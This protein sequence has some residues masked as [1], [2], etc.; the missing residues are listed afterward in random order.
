MPRPRGPTYRS[1]PSNPIY[2]DYDEMQE[3][4]E[5]AERMSYP[6][7]YSRKNNP[8][9]GV[10]DIEDV[11]DDYKPWDWGKIS[12]GANYAGQAAQYISNNY[13]PDDE[14][15]WLRDPKTGNYIYVK[16]KGDPSDPN[17]FSNPY[18]RKTNRRIRN[19]M[20][21][22]AIY[23]QLPKLP[24]Q[25]STTWSPQQDYLSIRDPV[26]RDPNFIMGTGSDVQYTGR[27]RDE[28]IEYDRSKDIKRAVD[29]YKAMQRRVADEIASKE[30]TIDYKTGYARSQP[31]T[32]QEGDV[33]TFNHSEYCFD[34]VSATSTQITTTMSSFINTGGS[35]GYYKVKC[36]AGIWSN[37]PILSAFASNFQ[38]YRW[39][40]LIFKYLTTSAD[41]VS[42][43]NTALGQGVMTCLYNVG[44]GDF[45]SRQQME[46]NG[47][48]TVFKPSQDATF[49]VN[50]EN[51]HVPWFYTRY[52]PNTYSGYLTTQQ[53]TQSV[54]MVDFVNFY[55]GLF[56]SQNSNTVG[57]LWAEYEVELSQPY[58][59]G[60][61]LGNSILY[62]RYAPVTGNQA[63][64]TLIN[65]VLA[66]PADA[67][68]NKVDAHG[69]LS[70]TIGNTITGPAG[71][72]CCKVSFPSTLSAGVFRIMY[73][74]GI[75]CTTSANYFTCFNNDNTING[76][77][78]FL[79][80]LYL[81][82][83]QPGGG[84]PNSTDVIIRQMATS[85]ECYTAFA[86]SAPST[87]ATVGQLTFPGN[88]YA[89][90]IAYIQIL[91]PNA[92]FVV[93]PQI[94]TGSAKVNPSWSNYTPGQLT[95]EQCNPDFMYGYFANNY[96]SPAY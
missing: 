59:F 1:D 80:P 18:N 50:C 63:T 55:I 68:G 83:H 21:N 3:A 44:S 46:N 94:G 11:P 14:E 88:T 77:V 64:G 84:T 17:Y 89:Y 52:D 23:T 66:Q 5:R 27:T 34:I 41:S 26:F 81:P 69:N 20:I 90:E 56:S 96:P 12:E 43:T 60:N 93:S 13:D 8:W 42:A 91:G 40:K 32:T 53:G 57:Q 15:E 19:T 85:A 51:Q 95:I 7:K 71:N 82:F 37:M 54:Q 29:D 39:K 70:M 10:S 22:R 65:S 2:E 67:S 38:C 92:F 62:F 75:A 45:I 58:L 36:N 30:K 24:G 76:N 16:E 61:I 28:K 87:C 86:T 33:I 4:Y 35:P 73:A 74:C 6:T 25:T 31:L 48:V 78:N 49:T 47:E 9:R 72:S 79:T